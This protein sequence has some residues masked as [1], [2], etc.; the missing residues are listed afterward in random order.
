MIDLIFKEIINSKKYNI[1]WF[2]INIFPDNFFNLKSRIKLKFAS[3]RSNP[4]IK[5]KNKII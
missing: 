2:I 4:T 1:F 3:L 5:H